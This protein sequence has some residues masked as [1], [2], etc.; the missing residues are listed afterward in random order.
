MARWLQ[1]VLVGVMFASGCQNPFSANSRDYW[2]EGAES[3]RWAV[4][5]GHNFYIADLD[6]YPGYAIFTH[7]IASKAYSPEVEQDALSAGIRRC[8]AEFSNGFRSQSLRAH[9][10]FLTHRDQ[11]LS[12]IQFVRFRPEW[13]VIIIRNTEYGGDPNDLLQPYLTVGYVMPAADVFD[14]ELTPEELLKRGFRDDHPVH[15]DPHATFPGYRDVYSIIER[16]RARNTD[17][18]KQ[19]LKEQ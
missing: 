6:R 10:A 7:S 13:V 2:G 11:W 15:R 16:F 17:V 3:S 8:R 12:G 14:S 9:D 1:Y 19:Y 5:P 18:V 4:Q